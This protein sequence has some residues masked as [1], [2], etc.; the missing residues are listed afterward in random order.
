MQ[1]C[2]PH[3]KPPESETLRVRPKICVLTGD[4][5]SPLVTPY[6]PEISLIGLN[7]YS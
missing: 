5:D 2:G 3:P 6:P 4:S 7:S 1:I